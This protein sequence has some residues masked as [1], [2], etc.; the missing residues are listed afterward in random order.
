MRLL[1]LIHILLLQN[2]LLNLISYFQLRD[3]IIGRI[4]N[5]NQWST[6]NNLCPVLL[7]EDLESVVVF[8]YKQWECRLR[9][10]LLCIL[11][12]LLSRVRT[13]YCTGTANRSWHL[14]T[15]LNKLLLMYL[16]LHTHRCEVSIWYLTC[17]MYTIWMNLSY[18]SYLIR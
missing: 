4:K 17:T 10:E 3:F 6:W 15:T 7:F 13:A 11:L 12:L 5:L 8:Y 2:P 14:L 16:V 9:C 1:F 18:W